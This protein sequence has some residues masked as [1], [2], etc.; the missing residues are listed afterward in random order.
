MLIGVLAAAAVVAVVL[1][2]LAGRTHRG[3]PGAPPQQHAP[4]GTPHLIKPCPSCAHDY[5][6]DALSGAK[7]Q[8]PSEDG[9]AIDGSL[10]TA[11][12]TESYDGDVLGKPGVGLFVSYKPPVAAGSMILHTSTPGYSAEIYATNQTPDLNT[13]NPGPNGWHK[14]TTVPK[15]KSKQ[16]IRLHT[17]GVKYQYYLVWITALNGHSSVAINEISLYSSS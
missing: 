11:W 14:L 12:T 16:T 7:N 5:N 3:T 17:D 2:L 10:S 13:F 8:H 9:L 4:K 1:V 15:V 6:P